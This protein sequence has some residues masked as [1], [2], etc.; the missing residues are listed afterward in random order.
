M[1][2]SMDQCF[3]VMAQMNAVVLDQCLDQSWTNVWTT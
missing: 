2:Q 1:D 3:P